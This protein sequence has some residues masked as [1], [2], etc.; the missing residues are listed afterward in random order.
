MQVSIAFSHQIATSLNEPKDGN[1]H[2][3]TIRCIQINLTV[4]SFC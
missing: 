3:N 2:F 4:F 1:N